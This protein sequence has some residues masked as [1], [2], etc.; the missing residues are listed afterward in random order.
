MKGKNVEIINSSE[1][2]QII[3]EARQKGISLFNENGYLNEQI[4]KNKN[5]K[6]ILKII[7]DCQD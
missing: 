4:F 2:A 7:P 6:F 1:F 3:E 5:F